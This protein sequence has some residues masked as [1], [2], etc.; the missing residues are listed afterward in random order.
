[1]PRRPGLLVGVVFAGAAALA[2]VLVAASL[3]GSRE[4]ADEPLR[5][6]LAGAAETASLLRGIPQD[7]IALGAP[8]APVT[9]VEYADLQCP[10]CAQWARSTFPAVVDEYVRGG[11]V[12]L[13]FR[14]LAFIGPESDVALRAALAA[15]RQQRLWNVVHL[16]YANQGSENAG[17]V[18]DDLLAD[19]GSAVGL[20]A[21]Q[22][23]A[24]RRSQV[25]ERELASAQRAADAAGIRGTPSFAAGPT[26]GRLEPLPITSPGPEEIRARLDALLRRG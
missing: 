4:T 7:G 26:G 8:D 15:G 23:L 16:L 22:M 5:L 24:E 9:L 14:G 6:E 11:R 19:V 25:V 17:W 2:A 12:R 13:V 20:D 3:L 10:Y 21:A 1:M 18:T